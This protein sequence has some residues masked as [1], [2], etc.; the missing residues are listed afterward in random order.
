MSLLCMFYVHVHVC[1][2]CMYTLCVFI[3]CSSVLRLLPLISILLQEA[4]VLLGANYAPCMRRDKQLTEV[5]E[6]DK[7]R[8]AADSGCCIRNDRSGCVQVPSIRHCPVDVS[9]A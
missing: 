6:N 8:E 2:M 4:L 1:V 5:L 3:L 9:V 7:A